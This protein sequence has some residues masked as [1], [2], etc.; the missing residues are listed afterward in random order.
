MFSLKLRAL[1]YHSPESFASLQNTEDL[2]PLVVWLEDRKIRCYKIE[3]RV[4]L[5]DKE[6]EA[7]TSAFRAYLKSLECPYRVETDLVAVADWLLNV[8]VRYDF[9][10]KAEANPDLRR[11]GIG[12]GEETEKKIAVSSSSSSSAA[13]AAASP[14]APAGSQLPRSVGK[15]PLDV[16]PTDPVFASGTQAL[17]NVLKITSHPD[18]AILL[19]AIRIVIQ[20]KLSTAAL[21]GVLGRPDSNKDSASTNNTSNT[22][23]TSNK[24]AAI[25]ATPARKQY[26]IT[27][28]ECGFDLGDPVLSEAAKVLRLLHIRELRELQTRI[29][30]LIV[31]V[32]EIT[33][34]PK[35][36]QSLGKVGR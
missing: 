28:K 19:Q 16:D 6:G 32:Q 35:T 22:S 15:S 17:A 34:D 36:D 3:D 11:Q 5:R 20:E 31:A 24:S 14:P 30:E 13:A 7:W 9:I 21:E 29:N 4:P 2:K 1:Q 23:N 12:R 33:A 10:E 25:T 18:P 8:A 26:K 27:A